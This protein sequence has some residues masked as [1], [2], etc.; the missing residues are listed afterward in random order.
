MK[1]DK[2]TSIIYLVTSVVFC[3]I[4]FIQ[5]IFVLFVLPWLCETSMPEMST[6][7]RRPIELENSCDPG[8]IHRELFLCCVGS[9]A[10]LAAAIGASKAV[11]CDKE[12][13]SEA[14]YTREN[15]SL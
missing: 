3:V 12:E 7:E 2:C 4:D 15:D 8:L 13:S 1:K 9:L 14:E 6:D 10:F 11:C 5:L